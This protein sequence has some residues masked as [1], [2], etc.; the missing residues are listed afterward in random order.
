MKLTFKKLKELK[1]LRKT[2]NN[3]PIVERGNNEITVDTGGIIITGTSENV[4]LFMK[5]M[6]Q[7]GQKWPDLS[8]IFI[9]KFKFYI[10]D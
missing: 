1:I 3:I 9:I 4:T 8:L 10:I 7:F 5:E 2:E 6:A